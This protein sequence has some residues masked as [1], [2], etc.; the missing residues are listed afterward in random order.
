MIVGGAVVAKKNLEVYYITYY[1][2]FR[3]QEERKTKQSTA[4]T[5][6]AEG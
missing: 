2:I 3:Q 1:S 6:G 5:A 4:T